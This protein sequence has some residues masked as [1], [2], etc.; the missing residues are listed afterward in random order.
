MNIRALLLAFAG[1]SIFSVAASGKGRPADFQ[2]SKIS[3]NFVTSPQYTYTGAEQFPANQ[4]NAGWKW[5]WS[6]QPRPNSPTTSRLS[7]TSSS[8]ASC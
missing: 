2:I 6:S 7:T 1:I 3:K 8:T 5:R 4:R